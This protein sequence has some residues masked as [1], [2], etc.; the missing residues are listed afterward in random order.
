MSRFTLAGLILWVG[1][2]AFY[3]YQSITS[4]LARSRYAG[5]RPGADVVEGKLNLETIFGA[6]HFGWVSDIPWVY[7]H[8]AVE[9]VVQAPLYVLIFALGCICL[10]IGIFRSD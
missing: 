8:K 5:Y 9:Y 3:G 10:L 7:V 1:S 2:F 6:E 4:L